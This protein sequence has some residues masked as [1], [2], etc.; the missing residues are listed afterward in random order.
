MKMKH[1]EKDL[2]FGGLADSTLKSV[3]EKIDELIKEYGEDA[4]Y[5]IEQAYH[6]YSSDSYIKEYL[7]YQRKETPE[8][9]EER[10]RDEKARKAVQKARELEQLERLKEKYPDEG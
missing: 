10:I 4:V 1:V 3:K 9:R 7:L 8:E 5:C 6:L 2:G